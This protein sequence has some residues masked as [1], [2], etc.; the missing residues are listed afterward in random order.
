M[1]PSSLTLIASPSAKRKHVDW[2]IRRW[3]C[4]KR[5]RLLGL[6]SRPACL[7]LRY[8]AIQYLF[9][10]HQYNHTW[11]DDRL[12]GEENADIHTYH[13]LMLAFTIP[14]H[15]CAPAQFQI[16]F[17]ITHA[18]HVCHYT[19]KSRLLHIQFKFVIT[20]ATHVCNHTSNSRLHTGA[21]PHHICTDN[22]SSCLHTGTVPNHVLYW[23][24][25]F[26]AKFV[27]TVP[28]HIL[29]WYWL[30]QATY[31]QKVPNHVLYWDVLFSLTVVLKIPTHV[32]TRSPI[33][34]SVFAHTIPT[35]VSSTYCSNS[36]C[37]D[38]V[39]IAKFLLKGQN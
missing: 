5:R 35:H 29:C 36:S 15:D 14:I 4:R 19:S 23:Y 1:S 30:F 17:V 38:S 22:H 39:G 8:A 32:C 26:Q 20:H 28:S 11:S 10:I 33:S 6:H 7:F 18:T 27:Q 31:V 2:N 21:I 16:T 3:A 13:S 9:Q 25:L 12:Q 24:L 34:R 37:P